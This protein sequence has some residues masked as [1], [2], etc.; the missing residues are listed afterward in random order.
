MQRPASRSFLDYH[1]YRCLE[2]R[3]YSGLL[4]GC[5]KMRKPTSLACWA[6]WSHA[7]E[8]RRKEYWTG[9]LETSYGCGMDMQL[10][11]WHLKESQRSWLSLD[12]HGEAVNGSDRTIRRGRRETKRKHSL[13]IYGVPPLPEIVLRASGLLPEIQNQRMG[14]SNDGRSSRRSE[15]DRG[16]AQ[17]KKSNMVTCLVLLRYD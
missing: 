11:C 15:R 5:S 16:P 6:S 13:F 2:R 12:R 4:S 10:G 1:P 3:E 17:D 7:R 8:W 14:G 9:E